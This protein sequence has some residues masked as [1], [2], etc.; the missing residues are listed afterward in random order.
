M[1]DHLISPHGGDLVDLF[2]NEKDQDELKSASRDWPSHDLTARQQCD[3]ELLICGG[4]SPLTG[5]LCQKDYES[6]CSE[7]RL[8]DGTLW[9]VP[10]TLDIPESLA[11]TLKPGTNLALRDE[12]GVMIAVLAVEDVWCPDRKAEASTVFGTTNEEH[13]GV[14]HRRIMWADVSRRCSRLLTTTTS[15]YVIHLLN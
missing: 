10:I 6:V 3:L 1:S 13:P 2:A 8:G 5:F 9:P 14:A 4:F 15:S 12:E 7:M 11:T